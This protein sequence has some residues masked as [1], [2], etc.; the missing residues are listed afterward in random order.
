MKS[1]F[2]ILVTQLARK[3]HNLHVSVTVYAS[4]YTFYRIRSYPIPVLQFDSCY[5]TGV[6]GWT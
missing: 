2:A 1:K 5:S 4:V 3:C 6:A